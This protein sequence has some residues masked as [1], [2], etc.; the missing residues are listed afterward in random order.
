MPIGRRFVAGLV[1]SVLLIAGCER[2]AADQAQH[3]VRPDWRAVTLPMPAGPDGRPM[4]RDAVTCA[5]RWYVVGAIGGIDGAT[6]PAA[7]TSADA[8]NWSA[9]RLVP[10]SYY[11]E[12]AILYAV[13]C[14][15]GRIAVIGAKAGGAHGNPRVRTWRQLPDGAL[16]EV[17]AAFELYGG[18]AAVNVSRVAGGPDGWLIAGGRES[19]AAVWRSPDGADFQLVENAPRLASDVELRTSA[20]DALAVADGWLVGGSGR[21]PGRPDHDPFVWWSP[22]GLTWDRISL[23][24]SG[25]DEAVHRLLRVG[26]VVLALGSRGATFGTW[27]LADPTAGGGP[28][29]PD[30]AAGEGWR[31]AAGFGVAG[32]G[33]IAGVEAVATYGDRV[34]AATVA[35][36]GHRL[37]MSDATADRWS[38]VAL[39]VAVP[40]GGDTAASIA[41]TSGQVVMVTDDGRESR[42]WQARLSSTF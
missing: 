2:P 39:P 23:P 21:A 27:R 18:P 30:G 33:M 3:Q 28:A 37:W 22:D 9:V 7:W 38:P 4:L 24:A 6:R 12:R 13:G 15:H 16:V 26:D 34:L 25:S 42:A 19:G 5:G 32:A 40:A 14:R 17:S 41:A 20:T 1:A 11:G 36:E 10:S 29:V 8:R 35:A 31:A